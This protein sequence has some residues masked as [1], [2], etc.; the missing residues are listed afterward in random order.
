MKLV[1]VFENIREIAHK[2]EIFVS[3]HEWELTIFISFFFFF[4]EIS[5][6]KLSCFILEINVLNCGI[7]KQ[8]VVI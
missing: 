7:V 8:Y 5:Q 2:L 6:F 4:S 1:H 3:N